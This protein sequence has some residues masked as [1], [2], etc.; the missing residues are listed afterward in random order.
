MIV[1]IQ[2]IRTV[3]SRCDKATCNPRT[4][5]IHRR[6][7]TPCR[8][9][10][11]YTIIIITTIWIII[12]IGI[13]VT[14]ITNSFH[15]MLIFLF[16]FRQS[17]RISRHPFLSLSTSCF[18]FGLIGFTQTRVGCRVRVSSAVVIIIIVIWLWCIHDI[19]TVT[20]G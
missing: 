16:Q 17:T 19:M 12:I 11:W 8:V 3:L 10:H 2:M 1:V 13:V 9:D 7:Q 14:P 20:P 6:I 5:I 15:M 4:P 18:N